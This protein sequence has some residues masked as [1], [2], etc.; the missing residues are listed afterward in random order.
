MSLR[1]CLQSSNWSES[2]ESLLGLSSAA[3]CSAP[4]TSAATR[5][6]SKRKP[7]DANDLGVD[8]LKHLRAFS[9]SMFG[10]KKRCFNAA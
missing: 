9:V 10:A 5:T 4:T 1:D 8:D 3:S 2:F 7:A 6:M